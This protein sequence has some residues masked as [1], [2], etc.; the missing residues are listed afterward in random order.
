MGLPQNSHLDLS[1]FL[2][3]IRICIVSENQNFHTTNA[4]YLAISRDRCRKKTLISS[5]YEIRGALIHAFLNRDAC[6]FSFD[7]FQAHEQ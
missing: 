1:W 7:F 2:K 6:G 3:L 4:I 5:K